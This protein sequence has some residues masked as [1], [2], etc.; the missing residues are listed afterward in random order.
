MWKLGAFWK[1]RQPPEVVAPPPPEPGTPTAA[2]YEKLRQLLLLV[3]HAS[4]PNINKLTEVTRN[5]DIL[6]L[7]V[8]A[9]GYGLARSLAVA[10][11]RAAGSGPRPVGLQSKLAT[12]A[13]IESDWFA[14]WSGEM[15]LPLLYHRKIWEFAYLLQAV[16]EHG[17]LR[18]GARG[19]GFGCGTEP[20]ASYFAAYGMTV[21]MTDL[22]PDDARAGD[23]AVNNEH[24]AS[25]D[26][27]HHANL[28]D[29]ATFLA[30]VSHA[31]VDMNAIPADLV[32]FDLCWSVCALE[33]LGSLDKG[34]AFVE[35]AMACLK[36]GGLAVHTTE[37]NL[38]PDGPT[39]DNWL[40]VLF[41][42]KHIEGL[43][44]RLRAQGHQVAP[45]NFDPGDQPLDRFIDLPPWHD[46]TLGHVVAGL[47]QPQHLK[48]A[49]DGF[50][51]TCIGLIITKAD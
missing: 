2:D 51:C 18:Q 11:P 45:L 17:Q 24:A 19:I 34:L 48:L 35:N 14:F 30:H 8:K 31:H 3:N 43:V 6:A 42:Q 47:G 7:N 37:F 32:D 27:A 50:A 28:V 15:K 25:L 16:Y 44:E 46:A 12:Q 36:P 22:A 5:L 26:A 29:R 41:Q 33:H 40:T 49:I 9:L 21:T 13:D 20:M 38:N 23:W 4:Q 10:L 39:I 1:R